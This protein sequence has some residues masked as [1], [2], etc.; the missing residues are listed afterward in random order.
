MSTEGGPSLTEDEFRRLA[1]ETAD[2]VVDHLTNIRNGPVFR[3]MPEAVRTRLRTQ[4]LSDAPAPAAE[5]LKDIDE[6]VLPYPMGNGHPRFFG[7]VNSAPAPIGVLADMLAAAQNPSADVGDIAALHVETAVLGWFKD[8]MGFPSEAAG[9]LVS[10]GTTAT[11]TGLAAA[12]QW[13]AETDG[14]DVRRDGVDPPDGRRLVLYTSE[15]AHSSVRKSV[16]LLGL[17]SSALRTVAVDDGYRMCPED[18]VRRIEHDIEAGERPFCVVATAG[19]VNTGAVDPLDAIAD[20][21]RRHRLWLHVDGAYGAI[22]KA[23]PRTAPKFDGLERADSLSMDPHKWMSVPI[24]CGCAMVRDGELL[25]RT[26]A[27]VPPYLQTEEGVGIGGPDFAE[28]GFQQT[29]SFRALKLWA[30]MR[31]MGRSGLRALIENHLTLARELAS[32]IAH[33]P[34]LHLAAPVG[35]SIVAFRY[36]PSGTAPEAGWLDD[37]NRA[38]EA[39]VQTD[40]RV[41]LTSTRLQGRVVL[42]ACVLHYGTR[43][44]DIAEL[45]S[46]VRDIGTDLAKHLDPGET[47][48]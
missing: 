4:E 38:I 16:E 29:R 15:E 43:S 31:Q 20:I 24:E 48:A 1:H 9:I 22:A 39:A 23:T 12:R 45:V 33:D 36:V 8:L 26:F 46:V 5:L 14:W 28:F 3:V 27:Y 32:L 19:T 37:L 21:C 10:G 13:V 42:R 18:L 40:G 7:W 41:F 35:L 30:V 11:M 6:L 34:L 2:L 47:H 25:R 44:E 17:G